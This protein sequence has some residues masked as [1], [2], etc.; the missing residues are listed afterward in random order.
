[1]AADRAQALIIE[2]DY[3]G[4]FYYGNAPQPA[5]RRIDAKGRVIYVGTFSKSL[6][7]SL[8]LG[9]IVVPDRMV[10]VFDTM[11]NSWASGPPTDP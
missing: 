5:L 11:F 3:D 9:Y 6:F 2:D 1:M 7:P 4:A 10:G 8:R